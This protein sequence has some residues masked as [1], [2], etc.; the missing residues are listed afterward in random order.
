MWIEIYE[1]PI[2]VWVADVL[3]ALDRLEPETDVGKKRKN[4]ADS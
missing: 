1:L 2:Q 3:K 4:E